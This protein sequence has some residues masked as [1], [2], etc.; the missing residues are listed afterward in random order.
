[1]Q[2]VVWVILFASLFPLLC[3]PGFG[4]NTEEEEERGH[5]TSKTTQKEELDEHQLRHVEAPN[6]LGRGRQTDRQTETEPKTDFTDRHKPQK[7]MP[8]AKFPRAVSCHLPL[9]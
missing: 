9:P 2:V 6:G 4:H 3:D 5:K 8:K 7:H 1:M